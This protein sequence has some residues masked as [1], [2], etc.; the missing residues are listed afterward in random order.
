MTDHYAILGVSSDATV[1]EVKKAFRQ[2]AALYHPDRNHQSNAAEL[3]RQAQ[4]AYDVLSDQE[5]RRV[6]DENRK[7][8]LLDD[9][10]LNAQQIWQ[11]YID[12]MIRDSQSS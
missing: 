3:F 1:A 5:K 4:Q 10:L 6:Y 11:S 9:P 2:K 7:R 12:E 8:N